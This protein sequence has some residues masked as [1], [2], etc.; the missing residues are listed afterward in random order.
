MSSIINEI[1]RDALD[2]NISVSELLRKSK[3]IAVKLDLPE[4]LAWVENELN[5]YDQSEVPEYRRV[6]GEPKGWNPINGWIPLILPPESQ[7]SI[8][9]RGISQKIG[10]LEEV[11][12]S[13]SNSLISPYTPELNETL[14]KAVEMRTKFALMLSRSA[15]IGILDA[16]RNVILD[17]SLKLEK[18]GIVGDGLTFSQEDK[19][20]A[21]EAQT[22]YQIENI[23]NFTGNMGSINDNATLTVQQINSPIDVNGLKKLITEIDKYKN[24]IEIEATKKKDFEEKVAELSKEVKS[25]APEPGKIKSILL[26]LKNILEGAAGS[27]VAQGILSEIAKHVIK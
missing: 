1:Q 20:K 15:V 2:S 3:V 17:W 26:S 25:S 7:T 18:A 8:S 14:S 4:F 10:E 27:I 6:T 9:S 12:K 21:H 16:V 11:A 22:I 13:D 19:K 5:G 23:D 24:Q